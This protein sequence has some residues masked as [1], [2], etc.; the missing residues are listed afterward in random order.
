MTNG[1]NCAWYGAEGD[2][3][4]AGMS[5]LAAIPIAGEG[6]TAAKLAKCSEK[7][8]SYV[9]GLGKGC[10]RPGLRSGFARRTSFALGFGDGDICGVPLNL[11]QNESSFS[12]S[13]LDYWGKKDTDEIVHSLRPG[14]DEP[15]RVHPNGDVANGNARLKVLQERGY[16]VHSL[17][18]ERY[19]G[20]MTDDDYLDIPR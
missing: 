12:R 5:C 19:S 10:K 17:P 9:K 13:S 8:V 16:D 14:A 2:Y 3:V 6:A 18:R 1:I 7:G 15:L 11:I 4:N 20:R